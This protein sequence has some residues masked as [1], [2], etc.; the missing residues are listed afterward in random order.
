MIISTKK[1]RGTKIHI[2]VD[3]EY[4]ATVDRDFWYSQTVRDGDNITD[5]ELTALLYAVSFRRS[6]NKA[7]DLLSRRDHCKKELA[8][9]L[10]KNCSKE[11]A[12]QVV[13]KIEDLG[14]INDENYANRYAQE[15]A[16]RKGMSAFRIKQ[17]LIRKGV[18]RTLADYATEELDMDNKQCII[19]LLNTKFAYRNL[20]EQK[21]QKRTINAL[22]R[23]GYSFGD[24]RSAMRE[25]GINLNV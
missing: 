10:C 6:Y 23:L 8:L 11:I 15:L 5:E 1:G 19:N 25:Q 7:L 22:L 13:D 3:D 4:T 21:E 18:D 12:N 2:S 9:K 16:Q 24:I 14:L 17:E 20:S